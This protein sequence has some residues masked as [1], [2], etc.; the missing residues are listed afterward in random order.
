MP[1]DVKK[2]IEVLLMEYFRNAYPDFP[3][4]K[5]IPSES[6][7]FI[8]GLKNRTSVGI[9]ITRLYPSDQKNVLPPPID[10]SIEMQFINKVKELVEGYNAQPLFVKFLFIKGHSINDSHILSAAIMTSVAIR[11][12]LYHNESRF[13]L[14]EI[15]GHSHLPSFL[16]SVLVMRHSLQTISLWEKANH[17]GI[18]NDI[19]ADLR[20]AIQKKDDKL[21]IYKSR[22]LQYYWLLI[23]TDQLESIR[24][25]NIGNQIGKQEFNSLFHKV[26]LFE[27]MKA[28]VFQLV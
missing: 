5:L 6:P 10:S 4:G 17:Q 14:Y 8:L 12:A 13:L 15:I 20:N 16:K 27:L 24:N 21:E 2:Q 11:N 26:F 22:N 19:A 9:E 7:D 25:V 23:T 28:R 3:K 1:L 18:S